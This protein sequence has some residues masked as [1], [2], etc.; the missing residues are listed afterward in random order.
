MKKGVFYRI[1]I[2]LSPA[3]EVFL[4]DLQNNKID[5]KKFLLTVITSMI[6]EF[7]GIAHLYV[8]MIALNFDPSLFAAVMGYIISVIFL[9]VSPFLRGLGAIEVSMTYVLIRFGFGNVEAIAITFL[10][11]FFEFWTP[12]FAGILAFL[13][14]LNKLLDANSSCNIFVGIGN[15]K[16]CFCFNSGYF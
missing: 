3:S 4:N 10:Y 1:I 2:K 7:I 5:S 15:I 13:S 6:I 14:K 16:Y 9:V 11:R 12:L 8:A